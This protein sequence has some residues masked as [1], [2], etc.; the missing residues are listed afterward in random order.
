MPPA[1]GH[2]WERPLRS[3][4]S[5]CARCG[6]TKVFRYPHT[7]YSFP[8]PRAEVPH[9]YGLSRESPVQ[10]VSVTLGGHRPARRRADSEGW[11]YLLPP[12]PGEEGSLPAVVVA[13]ARRLEALVAARACPEC[14]VEAGRWCRTL[15]GHPSPVL[16]AARRA[17]AAIP[18]PACA[19]G[20]PRHKARTLCSAC[21]WKKENP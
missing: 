14:L 12:C 3:R 15:T 7:I 4:S 11:T 21:H 20:R 16:H 5:T 17:A 2:A 18:V 6:L 19:C 8:D 10:Q 13:E 1:S 9:L